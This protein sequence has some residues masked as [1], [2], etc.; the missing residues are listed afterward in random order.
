MWKT[1]ERRKSMAHWSQTNIDPTNLPYFHH[2]LPGF[3]LECAKHNL[4]LMFFLSSPCK[5][6]FFPR[7]P[8]SY[9]RSPHGC[10]LKLAGGFTPRALLSVGLLLQPFS[11]LFLYD[12]IFG[13]P[14][15]SLLSSNVSSCGNWR[16]KFI[17]MEFGGLL[18]KITSI[19]ICCLS[20]SML[21]VFYHLILPLPAHANFQWAAV[22]NS[23]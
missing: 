1:K 13:P 20:L 12:T 9:Y 19:Y 17:K 10:K 11:S 21:C 15:H 4:L 22:I 18:Y 5:Y 23:G 3:L 2:Q 6:R 16:A 14:S 8:W 7:R